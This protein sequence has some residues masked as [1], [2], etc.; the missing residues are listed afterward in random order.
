[1][2]LDHGGSVMRGAIS[3]VRL[4]EIDLVSHAVHLRLQILGALQVSGSDQG[5]PC[6][7]RYAQMTQALDLRGIIGE[8]P[9]GSHVQIAEHERCQVVPPLVGL[10]TQQQVR[11]NGVVAQVLQIIGA[12]LVQEANSPA[13]LAQVDQDPP[14]LPARYA[15]APGAVALSSHTATTPGSPP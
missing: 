6:G 2:G 15:S 4:G 5:L 7:H 10:V 9:H 12:E 1:M 13:L 11:I 3:S 8:Q 14:T